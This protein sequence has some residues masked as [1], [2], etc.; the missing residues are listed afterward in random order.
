MHLGPLSDL[1]VFQLSSLFMHRVAKRPDLGIFGKGLLIC[2]DLTHT[3]HEEL[4]IGSFAVFL[5]CFTL[6]L[7]SFRKLVQNYHK[8]QDMAISYT[9][10]I[11]Q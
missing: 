6:V 8:P 3:A 2:N 1:L 7:L 4:S 5:F 10:L 9:N 11:N